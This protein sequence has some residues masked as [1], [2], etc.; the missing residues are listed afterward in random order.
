MPLGAYLL[1]QSSGHVLCDTMS[2]Q[3]PLV[4]TLNP[5]RFSINSGLQKLQDVLDGQ[6]T[7]N[8]KAD[9]LQLIQF[10]HDQACALILVVLRVSR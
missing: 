1:L 7:Q 6:N 8:S 2:V 4:A 3:C 5:R 9:S 10:R